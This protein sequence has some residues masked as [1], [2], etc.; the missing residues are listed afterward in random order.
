GLQGTEFSTH[1]ATQ[2]GDGRLIFGGANGLTVFKPQDI[3]D[4]PYNPPVVLTGFQI[5]NVSVSPGSQDSPLSRPIWDTGSLT[6]T[7]DQ[8]NFSFDFAALS[9]AAA[10]KNHYRYL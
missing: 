7:H 4:N 9:F 5:A 8:N 2:T 6:L 1:L 3:V 10:R